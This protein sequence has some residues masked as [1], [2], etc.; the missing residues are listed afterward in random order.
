MARSKGV[1]LGK[2]EG[3]GGMESSGELGAPTYRLGNSALVT[4]QVV[5]AL[6]ILILRSL[7]RG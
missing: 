5:I 1:D 3:K 2:M 4:S 7:D 6:K